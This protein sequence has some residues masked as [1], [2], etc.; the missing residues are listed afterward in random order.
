MCRIHCAI[1]KYQT[2]S[3]HVA[4]AKYN[5]NADIKLDTQFYLD[6]ISHAISSKTD[7]LQESLQIFSQFYLAAFQ[8]Q[9]FPMPQPV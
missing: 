7:K 9:V 1:K 5:L 3:Q 2:K 4:S 6:L 8:V